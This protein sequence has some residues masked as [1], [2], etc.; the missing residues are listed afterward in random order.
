MYLEDQRVNT[1]AGTLGLRTLRLMG[2]LNVSLPL[3]YEDPDPRLAMTEEEWQRLHQPAIFSAHAEPF[4]SS[5]LAGYR[6]AVVK[7]MEEIDEQISAMRDAPLTAPS[8]R[9]QQVDS[10]IA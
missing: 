7:R 6:H 2:F 4:A 9:E 3:Q 5:S 1:R 8:Q 10:F